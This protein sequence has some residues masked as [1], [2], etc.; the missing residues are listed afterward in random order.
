M[1]QVHGI[2]VSWMTQGSPRDRTNRPSTSPPTTASAPTQPRA[3]PT[4]SQDARNPQGTPI[5]KDTPPQQNGHPTPSP[6]N[7]TSASRRLSRSGSIENKPGPNGT[8][9]QRRNSWFSNIS[10]KFSSSAT[11]SPPSSTPAHHHSLHHLHHKEPQQK[12]EDQ[13]S[14]SPAPP[15]LSG[16][17]PPD[18]TLEPMPPKLHPTRNA[19][20]QHAAT[21]P[22]GNSP[23]TPAP[24]KASQ[25]GFLGVFRRLSSSSTNSI[26]NGKLGN[27]LVERKI[28]NID[29]NRERCSISE[30]REAKLRRV[31]F[32]VDVEIAPM[33]KY[34]DGE[35]QETKPLDKAQKKKL[36]EHGEGDAL[37]NPQAVEAKKEAEEAGQRTSGNDTTNPDTEHLNNEAGT[38]DGAAD[39]NSSA[40]PGREKETTKKKEKK[41]RS[42]E[43]RKARK[44]KRRKLAEDN[45]S[46]PIEIHYDS[47]D[48]SSEAPSGNTT[49]KSSSHPTT[50]PARIYRRCCQLRETPILKKITEQLMDKA[51]SNISAGTVNKLDLTDYYLQLPDLITLGDYLAVVPVKEIL[52]ENCGLGDEGLR[53]I[54]AG[55]L[56]AKMPPTSRRKKPKHEIEAQG[57]VVERVVIKNNKLGPDGWKH[58]SL[59]LYK[60]R[61]LKYLDISHIPFPKQATAAK[62]GNLSNGIH[63]P[64]SISDVFSKAMAD[65]LGGSTLEMVN[66]GETEPSMEQLGTIMDG[67]IKCGVR[68]LGLAHNSLDADG[69]RHVVRYLSGGFCEGL[70]LGGN[71][72]NEHIETLAGC[73]D[74]HHPIWALSLSGCNLT[75]SSLGKVLPVI[76]KLRGF[77]FIDLSHNQELFQTKPSALGLLRRYLPK[78][79]DLKRIHL[80]DVNMSSE[81]AIA[82]V[83][84]LPEAHNLAH[85][86]LLGNNELVKLA[87][88]KTEEAQEEACALYASL[89]AA[90]RISSSLVCVD[91]EV[92]SE[93]SGEI[94]KAM[95]KQVVAYC[96]R[97][98][99]RIPDTN[100]SAVIASAMSE[101]QSELQDGKIPAYPDV[102]AHLVGHDVLEQDGPEDDHEDTPDEDYV[103][104]GTGVVKA[105]ACCLKNRS[106]DS[107]RQSGEFAG[108]AEDGSDSPALSGLPTGGKAKDMSKH[109]LAGARKIRQ[110]LQPALHKA[111]A[112]PGDDVNLRKLTFLDE[113]L[114]GI[115]KRFEDEF[116]DTREAPPNAPNS[117]ELR[118]TSSTSSEEPV[119]A[120]PTGDDSAVAVSDGEDEAEIHAPKPLSRSNSMLSKELAEEEGRVLR[121]GH[122]FRSG[123]VRKEQFDLIS[124]IDDIGSDPKHSQMLVELAEDIGGELLEKVKEKGAVRAF[125]EDKDVLFRSMRDSDPEHWGRF[126][127]AQQKA[128]ANITVSSE[129]HGTEASQLADESAIAD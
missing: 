115:I 26:V 41:K 19:V 73:L 14:Q 35:A 95:A 96:L 86:N 52:L 43:E 104:G 44:E 47:T 66:I 99:E 6:T 124:T 83:E 65:R 61:S 121:A 107:H 46:V 1:E 128:R 45:G 126:V 2:D 116:P 58:I 64:R 51:N 78:L 120:G 38:N 40:E 68:R 108:G 76:A 77:R 93:G 67:I 60:C 17:P 4:P 100:I 29:Q 123:F 110:R 48:S 12:T 127:E 94:V 71:D 125:K 81:Q 89:M 119:H 5:A 34:A 72:I 79:E 70:D 90:A 117:N 21:K 16:S 113:T 88:A 20:L 92:P 112:E 105:L 111:R 63:I 101:S 118:K 56:A 7:S 39:E 57:G 87:D 33:P 82:L 85:V 8:P 84:V 62:N 102:L 28:L 49:P 9:P 22:E 50:N 24:P 59:F 42:E 3:I 27:G 53:V 114:Q 31:S 54:L 11:T 69:I 129:K 98:M 97:N 15:P 18:D 30:L 106:D 10:A 109:L 13:A 55:L 23:Y 37:K 74:E 32:C 75:P 103:I 80:Q 122:R 25:A 36:T 91:I